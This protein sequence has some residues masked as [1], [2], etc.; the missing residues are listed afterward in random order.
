MVQPN[1][2]HFYSRAHIWVN[3][4]VVHYFSQP[5]FILFFHLNSAQHNLVIDSGRNYTGCFWNPPP[6]SKCNFN[7]FQVTK[8]GFGWDSTISEQYDIEVIV[9]FRLKDYFYLKTQAPRRNMKKNKLIICWKRGR[10]DLSLG[11]IL[12]FISFV[13]FVL[14]IH[15]QK[16]VVIKSMLIHN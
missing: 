5:I 13:V 14:F 16:S 4:K 1:T 9:L 2:S 8:N 3:C 15:F 12:Y 11:D 10:W 7:L 6:P